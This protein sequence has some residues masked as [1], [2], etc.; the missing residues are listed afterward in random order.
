MRCQCH[1]TES[2]NMEGECDHKPRKCSMKS[3]KIFRAPGAE[4]HLCFGCFRQM[5]TRWRPWRLDPKWSMS[6]KHDE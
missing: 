3:Q 6:R 4:L 5:N 1:L 2:K